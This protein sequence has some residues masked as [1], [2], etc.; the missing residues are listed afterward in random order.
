MI[1]FTGPLAKHLTKELNNLTDSYQKLRS[2]IQVSEWE[3]HDVK[4][5]DGAISKAW[6]FNK[7]AHAFTSETGY[8]KDYAEHLDKATEQAVQM[9][10]A[11]NRFQLVS[12]LHLFETP[13]ARF[14]LKKRFKAFNLA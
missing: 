9:K 10:K 2:Y 5:E 12:E 14:L 3:L 7:H 6:V 1:R 8:P 11:F 4:N 13:I